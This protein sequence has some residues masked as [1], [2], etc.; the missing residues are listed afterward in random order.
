LIFFEFSVGNFL[1]KILR[2]MVGA[3]T[4]ELKIVYTVA[5][6]PCIQFNVL[7]QEGNYQIH[8]LFRPPVRE[9]SHPPPPCL[10]K[11]VQVSNRHRFYSFLVSLNQI[12]SSKHKDPTKKKKWRKN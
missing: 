11:F 8:A 12:Q 10:F 6:S 1:L 4:G 2:L 3:D 5:C 9:L 7:R